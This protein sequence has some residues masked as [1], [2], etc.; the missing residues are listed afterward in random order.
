MTANTGA[1]READS[2]ELKFPARAEHLVDVR[3]AVMRLSRATT[4]ERCQ[5]EDYLTA[6]DEAVANAIRHG[7]P[8]G[9]QNFV[10]VTCRRLGGA[11][12]VEVQ[13][14]GTGFPMPRRPPMPGPEAMGGRGLPLMIVL[15]DKMEVRSAASG[16]CVT[17]HKYP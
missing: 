7:S 2:I 9:E 15:A 5:I 1:D 8:Q 17:L 3:K 13:D 4:L 11:L 10:C 12:S 14:E 6:V 16:T